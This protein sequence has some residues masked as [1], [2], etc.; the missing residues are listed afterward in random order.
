MLN[1]KAVKIISTENIESLNLEELDDELHEL[2][3]KVNFI[4]CKDGLLKL[5][6]VSK[7]SSL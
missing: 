3:F 2:G 7:T 4:F 5:E 1:L 6:I